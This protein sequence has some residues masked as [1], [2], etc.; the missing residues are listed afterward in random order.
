MPKTKEAVKETT[1]KPN[2]LQKIKE[3]TKS[4]GPKT[5]KSGLW[6]KIG[7]TLGIVSAGTWLVPVVGIL[8]CIPALVFNILGL[9]AEKG[10]WF[11]VAGLT[12]SI[13]FLNMTFIYGF[14][15]V[16]ISMLQSSGL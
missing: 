1:K 7:F 9:R 4:K 16:L 8:V 14:Y 13:L 3:A 2:F 6:G 5:D 12:L 15:N 11:A 10:R